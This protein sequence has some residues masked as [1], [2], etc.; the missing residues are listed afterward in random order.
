M[1]AEVTGPTGLRRAGAL[2][3]GLFGLPWALTAAGSLTPRHA[4]GLL[5]VAV[6]V[7]VLAVGAALLPS[8]AKRGGPGRYRPTG[9]AG[10]TSWA[11]RR[12]RRSA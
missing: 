4:E 10:S 6:A 1:T 11:W 3:T 8:L 12:P 9:A 7:T 2:I 5:P